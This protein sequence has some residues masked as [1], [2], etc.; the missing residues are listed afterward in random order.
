MASRGDRRQAGRCDGLAVALVVLV[1]YVK[2]DAGG[3]LGKLDLEDL[4]RAADDV[5]ATL[6]G[7]HSTENQDVAEIVERRELCDA[8]SEEV[9]MVS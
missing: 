1:G 7:R 4:A 8:V 2:R 9:P 3:Q 5:V 6:A